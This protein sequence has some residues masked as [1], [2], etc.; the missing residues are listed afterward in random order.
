[1]KRQREEVYFL[2]LFRSIDSLA[3]RL[4]GISGVFQVP[5]DIGGT[6]DIEGF[7]QIST[8]VLQSGE[9]RIQFRQKVFRGLNTHPDPPKRENWR[10]P[11]E[12]F[13]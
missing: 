2:G 1:M 3:N 12:I 13:R 8:E 11:R 10:L 4:H 5:V 6:G 7:F 9:G